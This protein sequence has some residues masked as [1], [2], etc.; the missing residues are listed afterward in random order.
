MWNSVSSKQTK[1]YQLPNT[2]K[3]S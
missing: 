3:T 1:C 2:R